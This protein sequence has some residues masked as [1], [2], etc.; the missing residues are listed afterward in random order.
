MHAADL[1][2]HPVAAIVCLYAWRVRRPTER[3]NRMDSTVGALLLSRFWSV[4]HNY[5]NHEGRGRGGG[6]PFWWLWYCGRDVYNVERLDG[7]KYAYLAEA[8]CYAALF[9]EM[10]AAARRGGERSWKK[11]ERGVLVRVVA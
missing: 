4:L 1:L 8:A 2:A 3:V 7:W 10:R 6:L 9:W 5:V 11:G